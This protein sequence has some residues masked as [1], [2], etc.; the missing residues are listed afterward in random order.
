MVLCLVPNQAKTMKIY[1]VNTNPQPNGD[2][3][4]HAQYC[5]FIPNF[6]N[7]KYLGDFV[8]CDGAGKRQKNHILNR[9]AA[10]RAAILV[11]PLKITL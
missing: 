2:H 10:K 6:I 11:T 8:S 9:M 3:E 7:R 5:T 1:Y 4:V